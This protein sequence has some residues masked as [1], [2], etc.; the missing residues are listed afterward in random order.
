MWSAIGALVLGATGQ[1][2]Y[3]LLAE[4][5]AVR[6]PWV[7]TML[8][9]SLPVVVLGLGTALAHMLHADAT[10]AD[11]MVLASPETALGGPEPFVVPDQESMLPTGRLGEAQAAANVLLAAGQRVSRR[12]LRAA[13]VRGSN[14]ELSELARRL[15]AG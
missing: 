6:A 14:T 9:A 8:V 7:V 11:R 5:H 13:G 12:G 15:R 4:A 3:H 2:A 1:I 10:A